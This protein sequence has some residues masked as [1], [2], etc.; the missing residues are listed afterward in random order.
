VRSAR[1]SAGR[2][3]PVRGQCGQQQSQGGR[4]LCPLYVADTQNSRIAAVPDALDRQQSAG[5]GETVSQGVL[6]K[7]PLGLTI[8]PNGDM[9]TANGGDGNIVE[10]TPSGKQVASF[11][12]NA[13]K[14]GLFG[15][16]LKPEF[17]GVYFVDD[18]ENTLG[19]LH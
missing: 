5:D 4:E 17:G 13:E 14:G 2:F 9:I 6:L 3:A 1:E 7:S 18:K 19:L 12:T 8:A 11:E 16:T 10:T 15:L